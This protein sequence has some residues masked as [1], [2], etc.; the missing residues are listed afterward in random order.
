MY[1]YIKYVKITQGGNHTFLMVCTFPSEVRNVYI[2]ISR[3]HR[4][5]DSILLCVKPTYGGLLHHKSSIKIVQYIN[6]G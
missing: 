1:I 3:K 2:A 4:N 6:C 5:A